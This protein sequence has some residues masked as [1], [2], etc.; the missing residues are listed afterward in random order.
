MLQELIPEAEA[1]GDRWG[2]ALLRWLCW[3]PAE[4]IQALLAPAPWAPPASADPSLLD[5]LLLQ[6]LHQLSGRSV[7]LLLPLPLLLL[8]L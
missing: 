1:A 7:R 4:G 5:F 2:V 3:G 6:G 8:L